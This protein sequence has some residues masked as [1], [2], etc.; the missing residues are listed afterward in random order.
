MSDSREGEWPAPISVDA[1]LT[2]EVA[3]TQA[4]VRSIGERVF[5]M[6]PSLLGAVRA[7]RELPDG[8]ESR[9][10]ELLSRA[11]LTVEFRV[12]DRT[13][14]VAGVGARPGILSDRLGVE[15]I[16]IRV[17]GVVGAVRRGVAAAVR[18]I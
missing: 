4:E 1:D 13:V 10:D 17:A 7:F 2:V 3:G 8:S 18:A 5:V 16:E 11:D 15:T 6:F 14:A 9:L 12:R